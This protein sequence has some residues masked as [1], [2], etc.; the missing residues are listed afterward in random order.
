MTESGIGSRRGRSDQS[1]RLGAR[2]WRG[3]QKLATGF[4]GLRIDRFQDPA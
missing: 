4:G 3:L 1:A 2:E